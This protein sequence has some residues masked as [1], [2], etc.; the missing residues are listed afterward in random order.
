MQGRHVS[1]SGATEAAGTRL[2]PRAASEYGGPPRVLGAEVRRRSSG[3]RGGGGGRGLRWKI[4]QGEVTGCE[5]NSQQL[6]RRQMEI[7][8]NTCEG[9]LELT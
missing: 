8:E 7:R 6:T 4:G 1:G 5:L 9:N 3:R 2:P